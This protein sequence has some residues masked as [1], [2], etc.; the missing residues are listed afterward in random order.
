MFFE[1]TSNFLLNNT[2]YILVGIS[3]G[4]LD[5]VKLDLTLHWMRKR[6]VFIAHKIY[7]IH[8]INS[9]RAYIL[10]HE[11]TDFTYCYMYVAFDESD[12]SDH[13]FLV[14]FRFDRTVYLCESRLLNSF[15]SYFPQFQLS[16][17]KT[18]YG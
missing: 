11:G 2:P 9:I 12:R 5:H 15:R 14:K 4:P 10:Y 6:N 3:D 17:V 13:C 1:G 16:R 7:N 18:L 8:I